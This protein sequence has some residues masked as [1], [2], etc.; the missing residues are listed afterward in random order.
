MNLAI[1]RTRAACWQ[2]LAEFT[3]AFARH[4]SG[5]AEVNLGG[6]GPPIS[7]RHDAPDAHG[8]PA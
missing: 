8:E 1:L 2:G 3:L 4:A 7:A 5:V 6:M